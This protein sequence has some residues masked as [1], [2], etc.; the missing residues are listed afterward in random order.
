MVKL[1]YVL[2]SCDSNVTDPCHRF[3]FGLSKTMFDQL[4]YKVHKEDVKK[5]SCQVIK[6]LSKQNLLIM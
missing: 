5:H 3:D 1:R 6:W 4:E 2:H